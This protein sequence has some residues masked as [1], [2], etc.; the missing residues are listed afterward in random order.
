VPQAIHPHSRTCL[1]FQSKV[2]STPSDWKRAI[3]RGFDAAD[4]EYVR[5]VYWVT[6]AYFNR[7]SQIATA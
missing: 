1:S 5:P 3:L 4:A 7:L 2:G 6:V